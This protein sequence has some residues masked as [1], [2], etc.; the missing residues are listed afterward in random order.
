MEF[1]GNMLLLVFTNRL[2]MSRELTQFLVRSR[3]RRFSLSADADITQDDVTESAPMVMKLRNRSFNGKLLSIRAQT[4]QRALT[5]HL[6]FGCV[7]SG[8]TCDV[9]VMGLA[10]APGKKSGKRRSDG[11]IGTPFE[12]AFG[13]GVE[14][15]DILRFIDGDDGFVGRSDDSRKLFF[16]FQRIRFGL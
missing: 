13:G 3:Q 11:I 5:A 4:E 12:N 1:T 15:H 16:A 10:E 14:H 6:P 8:K 9:F 7:G 2:Y